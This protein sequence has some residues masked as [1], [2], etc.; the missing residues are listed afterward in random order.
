[1]TTRPATEQTRERLVR[2]R[3]AQ[4]GPRPPLLERHPRD[5]FTLAAPYPLGPGALRSLRA[6][7]LALCPPSPA[8]HS[9]DLHAR[10][11]L[12][13]RRFLRYMH[14]FVARTLSL[15]LSLLD[16]LPVLTLASAARLHRLDGARARSLVGNWAKSPF[17]LLRLLVVGIRGMVLSVYFD[18]SEVHAAMRYAPVPFIKSRLDARSRLLR[19]VTLAAE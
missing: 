6:L 1:M 4:V 10:V 11:E 3:L 2:R 12:G 13:A 5:G 7:I 17:R 16:W 9:A 8:P 19:P 14:P 18:Q 15:G